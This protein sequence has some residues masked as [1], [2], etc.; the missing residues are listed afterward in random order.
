[1]GDTL[2]TLSL[3]SSQAADGGGAVLKT[4]GTS[5]AHT[6]KVVVQIY[7]TWSGVTVKPQIALNY[8]IESPAVFDNVQ[9]VKDDGT[10]ADVAITADTVIALEIPSGTHFRLSVSG[11]GSPLP[12]LNAI[13][14]GDVAAA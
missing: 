2:K 8:G 6:E 4:A 13:A 12:S 9:T 11:S 10:L 1:M 3:F 5:Q 14:H 7:G